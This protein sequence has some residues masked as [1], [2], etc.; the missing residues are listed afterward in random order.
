LEKRTL[1]DQFIDSWAKFYSPCEHVAVDE[2]I[3]HRNMKCDTTSYTFDINA[4]KCA[5][6]GDSYTYNS[7]EFD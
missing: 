1:F 7:K 5:T 2:D 4:A 6:D 3:F